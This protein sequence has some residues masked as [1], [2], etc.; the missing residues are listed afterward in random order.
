MK[1]SNCHNP[2]FDLFQLL[3]LFYL[4]KKIDDELKFGLR[5]T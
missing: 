2:I 4:L 5:A 3:L 1:E